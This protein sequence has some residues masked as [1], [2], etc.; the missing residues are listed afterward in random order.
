MFFLLFSP[1]FG[2]LHSCGPDDVSVLPSPGGPRG[3]LLDSGLQ[4][5]ALRF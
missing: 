2:S 1:C 3:V 4:T 5:P